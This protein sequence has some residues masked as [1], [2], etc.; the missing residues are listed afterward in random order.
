MAIRPH[1][2]K[3]K[4]YWHIDYRPEGKRGKRQRLVFKGSEAEARI[5]EAELR[6]QRHSVPGHG[7][8]HPAINEVIPDFL[9]WAQVNRAEKTWVDMSYCSKWIKQVFG[10]LPVRAITPSHI[11]QYQQLRRGKK[12]SI[13]K[14]LHYLQTIVKWMAANDLAPPDGLG[15]KIS[16]PRYRRPKPRIF[17]PE[18]I[19]RFVG[20][21]N[22]PVKIAAVVIM[23]EAGARFDEV[24][25][26]QWRQISFDADTIMLHGKGDKER[27]VPLPPFAKWILMDCRKAP[28]SLVFRNSKTGRAYTSLKSLFRG[29]SSRAGLHGLTPHKLR[30]SFATDLLET[31]GDL[32]LVQKL[33]GHESVNTT[34]IYAH[35]R[36]ERM[37]RGVEQM[38]RGRR[39]RLTTMVKKENLEA[40][41]DKGLPEKDVI[42]NQ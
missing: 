30:H 29:A 25:S 19:E 16:V 38:L 27:L 37:Q 5:Y 3:G 9:A 20:E 11:T 23:Y 32:R 13:E 18:E 39:E 40:N 10:P 2:S 31:T 8:L 15:F 34:Q 14:E 12:R 36:K 7:R 41:G 1:P 24:A 22:D 28:R 4:G 17:M 33:L 35:V 42:R 21:I 6:R 26:L